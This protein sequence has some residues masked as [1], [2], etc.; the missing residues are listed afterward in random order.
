R[1]RPVDAYALWYA[2]SA[3]WIAARVLP[4]LALMVGFAAVALPLL[5][6]GE[7]G[8]QLP[9]D[10]AAAVAFGLS[11]GLALLLSAS[12]VMLLNVAAVA[13][14]NER[15]INALA[16]PVVVVLSGNLLPLTLM[17][18]AWQTALLLQ[19]LAGLID[20]P[21]RLYAAQ[22]TGWQALGA[23]ALQAFWAVALVALGRFAMGRTMRRLD[24]QG[25]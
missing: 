20:I 15:G 13:A 14:L 12:M 18:D 25:G 21:M 9:Q 16:V 19:P 22:F 6:W 3:G 5:G 8:W 2:R 4:R 10:A 1:L 24:V 23:L 17:P 11:S 7:W